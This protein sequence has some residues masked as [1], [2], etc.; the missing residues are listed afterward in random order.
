MAIERELLAQ[1]REYVALPVVR[2]IFRSLR[3]P[4]QHV[5]RV[6]KV[7]LVTFGLV[8]ASNLIELFISNQTGV[9]DNPAF[10]ESTALIHAIIIAPFAVVWSKIAIDGTAGV[11]G[12]G[13][14][15]LETT[16]LSYA[17]ASVALWL[18]FLL[19]LFPLFQMMTTAR[20]SGDEATMGVAGIFAIVVAVMVAF[21]VVRMS[22]LFPAIAIGR[23]QGVRAAW[24]QTRGYLEAL[25]AIEGAVCIVYLMI[26][27]FARH[28]RRP[29][30]GY[31][32]WFAFYAVGD[33]VLLLWEA[34]FVGGPAL[35]YEFLIVADDGVAHT[36][37]PSTKT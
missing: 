32:E 11:E 25:S 20:Q 16:E 26:W 29:D 22:F 2:I 17:V 33:A 37:E 34:S 36:L 8:L 9:G 15:P 23:Y 24:V 1:P 4:F 6:W 27:L 14:L 35:A 30:E 18:L 7:S 10:R 21:A 13:A 31:L 19:P 3:L 28:F 12:S 5:H